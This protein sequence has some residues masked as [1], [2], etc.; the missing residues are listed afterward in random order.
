MQ[1]LLSTQAA[2]YKRIGVISSMGDDFMLNE[3]GV[4]VF[5]NEHSSQKI[6]VS[7]N[8][9]FTSDVIKALSGRYEVTDL[10]RYGKQFADQPKYWPD[11]KTVIGTETRPS[12]GEVVKRLVA[13]EIYD[14]YI[15]IAPASAHVGSTNQAVGG[16]GIVKLQ[17]LFHEDTC[18]LHAAYMV[19]VIDGKDYSVVANMRASSQGGYG[20]LIAVGGGPVN[21][22]NVQVDCQL[23]QSPDQSLPTIRQS[24]D[25]LLAQAVPATLKDAKLVQ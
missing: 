23:W 9:L 6:D 12:A 16:V 19:S 7:A 13:P 4:T 10:S 11:T 14:A 1:P 21:A 3:V 15:I 8:M 17:G 5:G 2:Q 25:T 22:P 20:G 24:L 18:F